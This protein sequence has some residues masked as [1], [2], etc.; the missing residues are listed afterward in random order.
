[1]NIYIFLPLMNVRYILYSW[2]FLFTLVSTAQYDID[3]LPIDS[4]TIGE[5]DFLGKHIEYFEENG[6]TFSIDEVSKKKFISSKKEILN[7]GYS[8][9]T[10]WL[11]FRIKNSSDTPVQ[12]ILS[13]QKSLQDT[14]QFFY[15]DQNKLEMLQ[16]GQMISEAQKAL[17]GFSIS[18]PITLKKNSIDTFYLRTVSKYGKSFAIKNL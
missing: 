4:N 17:P 10:I 8:Q 1:M 15:R 11:R 5:T 12:K 16:S 7:F 2:F 9:K 6:R 13:I 18:F 3:I 14:V